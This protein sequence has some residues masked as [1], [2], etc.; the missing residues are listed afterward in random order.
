[1]K[2]LNR[3][4]VYFRTK[5]LIPLLLL[6]LTGNAIAGNGKITGRVTDKGNGEPL[7]GVNVVITHSILKDGVEVPL[8]K[9]AGAATD[10]E[11]YYF[12]LNIPPGVYTVSASSIGY[13][14][15]VQKYVK[16]EMDRTISL[17]YEMSPASIQTD[18]VII[19]AKRE[20][21][22]A[23][24]SGTQ[25]VIS[26]ARIEQMPVTRVDEFI[27][28]MKGIELISGAEGNG[29]SVRGGSIR[30][31]DIRLDGISLQDPRSGNSYL[32]LN[33]TTILETQV[34]T[35]GFEAKY[36]G[37]Q[38][39]LLNVVTKEGQRER[40]TASIKFDAAPA[41]QKRYFGTDPW[42]N[43]S[44]IYKVYSGKYAMNGIQTHEDSMTV[45]RDFWNFKGWKNIKV[46]DSKELY[47]LTDSQRLDVW[48]YQHPQYTYG[49]K[50]DYFIEGSITG[51]MP[52]GFIPV[53][54][55]YAEKTTFLFGFKYE[56]SQLAF[57]LGARDNYIDMNGQLK[58]TTSLPNGIKFS[59]NG[60]Y[61]KLSTLSGGSASSYG[62][63]LVN[64]S[65]SFGFLNST[66]SSVISQARLINGSSLAQIYNKS[67]LQ[68]F[69][70]RYAVGGA[71]FTQALSARSF[72]TIEFTMGYTDQNL[73]PFRTDTTGKQ[74]MFSM[75]ST[76]AKRDYWFFYPYLG[77]PNAS[78]NYGTDG[79][80]T[81]NMYGG[82]QRIDSSYTY[83]YQ[84]K[85]DFTAQLGRHNQ[86]EAGFSA[87]VEDFFIY[88]GTWS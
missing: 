40:Y 53:F 6:I 22:K 86:L 9:P 65:S 8:A 27:G 75:Y 34:L 62:G 17:N 37:V 69:D 13:G 20:I 26:S 38:S 67:R 73:Q 10:A 74:N 2:C 24:V 58:L 21:I 1:M 16:V 82:P 87:R 80:G 19:T 4:E 42:S 68:F 41:G 70:Q 81:F 71:K 50:P 45:P 66:Q 54:G 3:F 18:Q 85:G 23:D 60:M 52:G 11:G 72:Y 61:A 39:G 48:K 77:S 59:I 83:T 47:P 44:W 51:P 56:N 30:E 49:T 15:I 79:L 78:T 7:P 5:L 25:E 12:I 31:T 57:P 29:L 35:G 64:S 36:G 63:A 84:L 43:D 14:T 46:A 28:K 32:A 88:A 76:R 55:D 33:S